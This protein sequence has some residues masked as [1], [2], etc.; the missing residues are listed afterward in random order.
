[1]YPFVFW[2][3]TDKAMNASKL[4]LWSCKRSA[5]LWRFSFERR[6]KR[7]QESYCQVSMV[8]M[9]LSLLKLRIVLQQLLQ[10]AFDI[11]L[12]ILLAQEYMIQEWKLACVVVPPFF[13][14]TKRKTFSKHGDGAEQFYDLNVRM[15]LHSSRHAYALCILGSVRVW[16]PPPIS[17]KVIHCCHCLLLKDLSSLNRL[18][19]RM[20]RVSKNVTAS[21]HYERRIAGSLM[22]MLCVAMSYRTSARARA[23]TL[24]VGCTNASAAP[25]SRRA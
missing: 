22:K 18:R 17:I 20:W 25:S 14:R 3:C 13:N 24:V 8:L 12:T 2:M 11:I 15:F 5:L 6:L 19:M 1:M 23:R 7:D 16:F 10:L 9:P 4:F 21:M